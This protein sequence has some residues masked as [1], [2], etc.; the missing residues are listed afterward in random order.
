MKNNASVGAKIAVSLAQLQ[1]H[2]G[3]RLVYLSVIISSSFQLRILSDCKEQP[4]GKAKLINHV[5]FQVGH[6]EVNKVTLLP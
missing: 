3:K 5:V 6:L 4:K 1:K 2:S